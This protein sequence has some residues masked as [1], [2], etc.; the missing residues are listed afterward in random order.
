MAKRI[1][2]PTPEQLKNRERQEKYHTKYPGRGYQSTQR[3]VLKNPEKVK[4]SRKISRIRYT[5]NNLEKVRH[6]DRKVKLKRYGLSIEQFDEMLRSQAFACAICGNGKAGGRNGTW[7]V[8]HCH[9]TKKIRG[10]LC[11][12]CNTAL[13][14]FKDNLIIL[15]SAIIYLKKP[16][17]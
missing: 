17:P 2:N 4:A 1:E 15:R 9:E 10:L 6:K 3:W 14:L 12:H 8:D 11:H 16:R 13:G 5:K 7:H